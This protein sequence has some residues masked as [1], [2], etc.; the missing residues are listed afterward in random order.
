[1]EIQSLERYIKDDVERYG[2]KMA[3]TERKLHQVYEESVSPTVVDPEGLMDD[4]EMFASYVKVF[5]ITTD[6]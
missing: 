3:E 1:M 5:F 2:Y 6:W 4:D